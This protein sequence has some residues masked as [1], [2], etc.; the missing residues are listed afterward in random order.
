M[1]QLL[2][3]LH[4]SQEQTQADALATYR[5][6]LARR[7]E[8]HDGDADLLRVT[9]ATL[10]ITAADFKADAASLAK[11][12]GL[13]RQILTP[14]ALKELGAKLRTA[15]GQW[16]AEQRQLAKDIVDGMEPILLYHVLN[17]LMPR[18]GAAPEGSKPF[19]VRQTDI[20]GRWVAA[21]NAYN[22]T[23]GMH[24]Q[25]SQQAAAIRARHPRAFPD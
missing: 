23:K 8:P 15:E 7:D 10:G 9:L 4:D 25:N 11:V 20:N 16:V 24:D 14:D 17:W 1:S 18:A 5:A 19:G 12:A 22:G 21:Q 3:Q 13:E 2:D 6:L